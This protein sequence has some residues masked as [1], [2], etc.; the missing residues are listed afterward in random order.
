MERERLLAAM[1]RVGRRSALLSARMSDGHCILRDYQ[2]YHA[3]RAAN[4]DRMWLILND[5]E[6]SCSD[7]L[8]GGAWAAYY[9]GV[10][11]MIERG[12]DE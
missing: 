7:E 11:S 8:I 4:E 12:S 9:D 5:G 6:M 10:A 2:R 3:A 1:Y